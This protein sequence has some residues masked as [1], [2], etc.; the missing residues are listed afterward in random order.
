MQ[1]R[2]LA[3]ISSLVSCALIFG[4][5]LIGMGLSQCSQNAKEDVY[6]STNLESHQP[7]YIDIKTIKPVYSLAEGYGKYVTQ[8]VCK[9]KTT[10]AKDVWL[11]ISVSDYKKHFDSSAEFN[12]DALGLSDKYKELRYPSGLRIHG[13]TRN[14]DDIAGNLS[15]KTA[16]LI[17]SFNSIGVIE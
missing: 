14:A 7:A 10:S 17:L 2:N 15:K 12:S 11:H 4:I 9:C 16:T 8:I 6:F 3:L 5:L 13:I 1:N